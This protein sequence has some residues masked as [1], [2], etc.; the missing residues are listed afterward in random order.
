MRRIDLFRELRY[1]YSYDESLKIIS[2]AEENDIYEDEKVLVIAIPKGH[3]KIYDF[4]F[5]YEFKSN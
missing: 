4:E 1:R 5:E 2:E 3:S